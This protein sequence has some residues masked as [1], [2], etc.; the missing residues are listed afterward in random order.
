[1]VLVPERFRGVCPFGAGNK[2]G[3]G[4]PVSPTRGEQPS[5]DISALTQRRSHDGLWRVWD[6]GGKWDVAGSRLESHLKEV[7]RNYAALLRLTQVL[8]AGNTPP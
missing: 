8:V 6:L 1:M 2:P 7:P 5:Q 4:L 3:T